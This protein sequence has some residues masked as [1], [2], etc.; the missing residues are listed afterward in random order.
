M[1]A[2]D[3]SNPRV[4]MLRRTAEVMALRVARMDAAVDAAVDALRIRA[5]DLR[6]RLDAL[7]GEAF[8]PKRDLSEL[9]IEGLDAGLDL[10]GGIGEGAQA[11]G[12]LNQR[13]VGGLGIGQA[14]EG[15]ASG[16]EMKGGLVGVG[17]GSNEA[18]SVPAVNREGS[19]PVYI[20][21]LGALDL[22]RHKLRRE[23]QAMPKEEWA[24]SA[25]E[26]LCKHIGKVELLNAVIAHEFPQENAG[27]GL[28]PLDVLV[29][30]APIRFGMPAVINP[31][32]AP[33]AG[34]TPDFAGNDAPVGK[35]DGN[36]FLAGEVL[37]HEARLSGMAGAVNREGGAL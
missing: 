21:L 31:E 11:V 37:R 14:A 20:D 33:A 23:A 16:V 13:E 32:S 5:R 18:G 29:V 9:G 15:G 17:H 1:S 26:I 2:A 24:F 12:E 27:H 25:L 28:D 7:L 34:V 10:P 35:G 36:G 6:W 30:R 4:E 3:S 19:D 8:D 22:A